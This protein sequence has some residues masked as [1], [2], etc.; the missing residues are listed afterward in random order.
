MSI[1]T[2]TT[3]FGTEDSYVAAM[4]GV[5]LSINPHATIVDVTHAAP[6]QDVCAAAFA[7]TGAVRYFPSGTVHVVVVD[8]GVGSERRPIAIEFG[9]NFFVG[10]DNGVLTQAVGLFSTSGKDWH[11][12]TEIKVEHTPGEA[13][14]TAVHL[15]NRKFWRPTVSSTFH[16]RDIFAP[17]AAHLSKGVPLSELGQP[18]NDLV[19]LKW[20][21]P[22]EKDDELVGE[23]IH[24]D[25]FGNLI[26]NI[27]E[28]RVADGRPRIEICGKQIDGLRKTYTE[29]E[30]G[31][32]VALVGSS[33]FLEIAVREGNAAQTLGA[34]MGDE[35]HVS[36]G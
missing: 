27:L 32:L 18:I 33:S 16:G 31:E 36:N 5:I 13:V 8:P 35:V 3:D 14:F 25:R 7:L 6:P 24:I 12:S 20:P 4:K 30:R 21:Q 23:I 10:P 29:V 22:I 9:G 19:T 11:V 1:I 2:L 17:V 26:T 34:K 28:W 15:T